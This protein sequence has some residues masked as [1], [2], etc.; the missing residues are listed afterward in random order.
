[1]ITSLAVFGQESKEKLTPTQKAEKK[2]EKLVEVLELDKNQAEKVLSI[3]LNTARE[4]EA[5]KKEMDQIK[6]KMK[7][8]RASNQ[9]EI[10]AV[11]TQEQLTKLN[12]LKAERKEKRGGNGSKSRGPRLQK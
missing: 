1:M 5:L 7:T 12:T 3:N 4:Q 11:L 10:E 2:T 9:K 8:S 6:Q